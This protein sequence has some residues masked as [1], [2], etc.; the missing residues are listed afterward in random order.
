MNF[1]QGKGT[2][3]SRRKLV[4]EDVETSPY[5]HVAALD[6]GTTKIACLV[7]EL[8]GEGSHPGAR[9]G[10]RLVFLL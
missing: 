8:D 2:V 4:A 1:K 3:R 9:S 6:V 5:G 10:E 7:G